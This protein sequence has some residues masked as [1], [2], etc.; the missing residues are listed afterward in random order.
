[1]NEV[2]MRKAYGIF[3]KASEQLVNAGVDP[4]DVSAAL[5]GVGAAISIDSDGLEAT[6]DWFKEIAGSLNSDRPS[7]PIN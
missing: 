4:A 3:Q 6:G 1:M 5:V 7:V 2:H